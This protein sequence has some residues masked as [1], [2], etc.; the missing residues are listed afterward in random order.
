M[1]NIK[2]SEKKLKDYYISTMLNILVSMKNNIQ[3]KENLNDSIMDYKDE[4]EIIYYTKILNNNSSLIIDNSKVLLNNF[5]NIIDSYKATLKNIKN[6]LSTIQNTLLSNND[7]DIKNLFTSNNI[8]DN[9]EYKKKSNIYLKLIELDN[10]Y[11][12]L[13][14]INWNLFDF[15]DYFR[16]PEKLKSNITK[17]YY[18]LKEF[19]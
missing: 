1:D 16:N 3:I 9:E 5:F 17:I 15:K 10:K 7:L 6:E 14:R 18:E 12:K 2:K 19:K 4:K 11:N 13:L 8:K